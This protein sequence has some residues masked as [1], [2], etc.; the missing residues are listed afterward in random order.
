[1]NEALSSGDAKAIVE[2]LGN[3]ARAYGLSQIAR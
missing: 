1:M 2:A 3:I